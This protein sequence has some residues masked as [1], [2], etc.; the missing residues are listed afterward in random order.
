MF[1]IK[2]GEYYVKSVDASFGGFINE[3]TLS[4][5][6]MRECTKEGAE[7]IAKMV[8]GEVISMGDVVTND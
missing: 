4:K 2:V 7:R 6:I 8:N 5:E 1:V 3:I